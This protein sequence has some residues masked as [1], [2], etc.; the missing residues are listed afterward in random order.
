MQSLPHEPPAIADAPAGNWVD[1]FIP[2]TLRPYA[3]LSRL[4]RPIGWWLLLLPCLWSLAL[5]TKAT[6]G[7]LPSLWYAALFIAGSIVMRGAGCT[8]NDIADRDID[9]KV[10]RTRARPIPAGDVTVRAAIAY[11]L[12]QCLI[13]LAVLLQFNWHTVFLG[14]ASLLVVAIYPFMKRITDWP[15]LVLG[16]AFNWGALVGWSAVT[17][18]LAAAPILLYFGG[19]AW[20]LAYDTIYALQ[21]TED[22]ALIGVRSTA[23]KFGTSSPY[24]IAGFFA[25]AIALIDASFWLAGA[26]LIAHIGVA[27]AALHTAW[28]VSRL[29][30]SSSQR[31]LSLFRSNRTFGLIV[32]AGILLDCL[33]P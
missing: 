24:W 13:G 7:G 4:D 27:G 16:F 32:L 11:L 18:S 29:E 23:L 3:R 2:D 31:C 33:M 30:I 20:T 14:A 6:G 1:R 26:G 5:A 15:Q 25:L 21:D 10:A 9:V 17:G 19:V 12:V 28:Q 8:L 22:D